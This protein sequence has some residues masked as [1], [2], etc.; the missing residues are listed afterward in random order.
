ML[1]IILFK[2]QNYSF[3]IL[4]VS[5]GERSQTREVNN[6]AFTNYAGS[7]AMDTYKY[8]LE[9]SDKYNWDSKTL[10]LYTMIFKEFFSRNPYDS[11]YSTTVREYEEKISRVKIPFDTSRQLYLEYDGFTTG[12]QNEET[13]VP[14]LN[15]PLTKAMSYQEKKNIYDSYANV[16]NFFFLVPNNYVIL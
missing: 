16:K 2:Q 13:W 5:Y 9:L 6:D 14:Y 3:I 12:Q 10:E 15:Y 11:Q 1:I 7:L 8:A 4:A